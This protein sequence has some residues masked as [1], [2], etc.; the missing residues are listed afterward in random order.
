LKWMWEPFDV[1]LGPQP[2]HH[3]IRC[4]IT[5]CDLGTWRSTHPPPSMTYDCSQTAC[6]CLKWMWVKKRSIGGNRYWDYF[7]SV[8]R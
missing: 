3:N 1:G 2:M 4:I 8:L 6:T 7:E 5:C